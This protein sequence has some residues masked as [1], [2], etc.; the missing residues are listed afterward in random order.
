MSGLLGLGSA[1]KTVL[2]KTPPI[3]NLIAEH[4][5]EKAMFTIYLK[6]DGPGA[7]DAEGG[8]ESNEHFLY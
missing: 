4:Q 6:K 1:N 2:H 3:I 8:S 7:E 5:L